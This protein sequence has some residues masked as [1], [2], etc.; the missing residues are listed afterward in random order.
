MVY[1]IGFNN[2]NN[3][4]QVQTD[5]TLYGVELSL[6]TGKA[7]AYLRYK[8]VNWKEVMPDKQ[9]FFDVIMPAAGSPI[10]PV[11]Q[12]ANGDLVQDTTEIIDYIE[13]KEPQFSVYPTGAK[14]KLAALL[15][16]FFGDEWLLLPAMHYRWNYLD[17]QHDFIMSEFGRQLNP[18]AS[19]EQQV[20]LGKKNSP[21]FRGS[22]PKMGVTEDTIE[23][24]ES[25]YLA[26]LDQLNT[27]F[28]T[29]PYLFGSRPSIGDYGLHASLYAHLARDPYPKALM[30]E[31]APEV[32]K[33]VERMNK[34]EPCS[35]EFLKNDDVPETL[36]PILQ[37][38]SAEQIPDVLNVI[39]ANHDFLSANPGEKIPRILGFHEFTI[40]G[41]TGSRWINSYGQWMFQRPLFFYQS[42]SGDDKAACDEL[43]KSINAYDAFQ[44]KIDKPVARRKGQLELVEHT[45]N[46]SLNAF[47]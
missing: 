30:Q 22:V 25:S 12:T 23:G 1:Q 27:H 42:L 20:E 10:I 6:Y 39:K 33:W 35:G 34:P 26:T 32:Y 43:L 40:G 38:Q 47:T 5:Y 41:K 13:S 7:R 24:V 19:F 14:Q 8:G 4:N 36:I 18:N 37:T 11:M 45:P 17:Q 31:K 16:E 44:T 29:H 3:M 21:K 46:T 28:K 15:L 2:E 9:A